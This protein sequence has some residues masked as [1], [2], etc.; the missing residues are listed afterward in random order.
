MGDIGF[1]ITVD[2]TGKIISDVKRAA[3]QALEMMGAQC[4]NYAAD[5]IRSNTSGT[6]ALANSLTHKVDEGAQTVTIGTD[7]EYAAYVEYGTGVYGP[8]GGTGGGWWV[9][10]DGGG[11]GG[12][13]SG[14]RYTYAEAVR[15]LA[16][17]H[18]QGVDAH[19]TQGRRALHFLRDAVDNHKDEYRSIA[20][21]AFK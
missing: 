17:L 9:Y 13:H 19:M 6:G 21:Q 7:M 15:V 5:T 8:N 20:E 1:E 10:V 3:A 4:Q 14:K 12:K 2:N 11:G 18:S 16:I